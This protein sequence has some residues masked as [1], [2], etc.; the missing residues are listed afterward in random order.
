MQHTTD[1]RIIG[2]NKL[3]GTIRTNTSKNGSVALLCAALINQ[4]T[5][6][7]RGIAR[8]EEVCRLISNANNR[9][10]CGRKG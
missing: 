8:I 3:T 4:N 10:F 2:G 6:R 1:F 9:C 7:L 5:T